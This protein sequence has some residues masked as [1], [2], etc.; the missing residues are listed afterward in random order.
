MTIIFLS[1]KGYGI[2]LWWWGESENRN[3]HWL[4]VRFRPPSITSFNVPH[5]K[6]QGREARGNSD[7]AMTTACC[8]KTLIAQIV[9]CLPFDSTGTLFFFQQ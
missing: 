3:V 7:Q 8:E 1:D 5:A 6:K 4:R 9:G 2:F